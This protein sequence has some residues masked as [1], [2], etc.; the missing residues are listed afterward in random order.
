MLFFEPVSQEV[1]L[2]EYSPNILLARRKAIL[3]SAHPHFGPWPRTSHQS[4]SIILF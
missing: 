2:L 3:L 1:P 4:L